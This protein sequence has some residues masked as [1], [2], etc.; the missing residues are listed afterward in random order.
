M[1]KFCFDAIYAT[2]HATATGLAF[3]R[4]AGLF[5]KPIVAPLFAL[6]PGGRISKMIRHGFSEIIGLSKLQA[7]MLIRRYPEIVNRVSVQCW[8]WDTNVEHNRR[9]PENFVLSAGRTMRDF[10][11]FCVGMKHTAA[12]AKIYGPHGCLD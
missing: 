3:L 6:P 11:S 7:D 12:R 10:R 2:N 1:T 4:S 5:R 8:G 9:N